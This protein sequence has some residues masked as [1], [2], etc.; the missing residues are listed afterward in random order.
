MNLGRVD[1]ISGNHRV[2]WPPNISADV[3]NTSKAQ[4][5]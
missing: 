1:L 3:Y 2:R 5:S 4:K